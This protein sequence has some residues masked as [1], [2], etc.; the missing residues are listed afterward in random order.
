[1]TYKPDHQAPKGGKPELWTADTRKRW[2]PITEL[3][4]FIAT[5]HDLEFLNANGM[6]TGIVDGVVAIKSA[7][8]GRAKDLLASRR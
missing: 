1:M 8:L 5:R 4:G 7:D 6:S 2:T 3:P